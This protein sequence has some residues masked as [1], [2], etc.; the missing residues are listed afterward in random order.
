VKR[1]GAR[2]R[3][4]FAWFGHSGVYSCIVVLGH[5]SSLITL[6][7]PEL[8]ICPERVAMDVE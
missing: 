6:H 3:N 8:F 2:L 5:G 1:G 7:Y 4:E